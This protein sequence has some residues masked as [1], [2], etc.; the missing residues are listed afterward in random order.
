MCIACRRRS[1][2]KKC[3]ACE[4]PAIYVLDSGQ[5]SIVEDIKEHDLN[6]ILVAA[7][8]PKLHEPTFRRVLQKAGLNP[9]YDGNG[10]I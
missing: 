8:S 10:D 4:R 5:D 6:H 1:A 9:F 7:C 3:G 2:S